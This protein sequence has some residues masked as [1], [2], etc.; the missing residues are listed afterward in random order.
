MRNSYEDVIQHNEFRGIMSS[1]A[2]RKSAKFVCNRHN[3][4]RVAHFS[5]KMSQLPIPQQ[6]LKMCL[7]HLFK[8]KYKIRLHRKYITSSSSNNWLYEM[9]QTHRS[10]TA[11]LRFH[12]SR[13]A[14]SWVSVKVFSLQLAPPS[15]KEGRYWFPPSLYPSSISR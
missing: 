10:S 13:A 7:K 15:T 9:T 11:L 4:P 1:N 2:G 14:C 6:W 8:R 12:P 3:P 5:H